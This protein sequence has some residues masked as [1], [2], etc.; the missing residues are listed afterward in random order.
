M[1]RRH[2]LTT[3]LAAAA[4]LSAAQASAADDPTAGRE[5]YEFRKYHLHV[6]SRKNRVGDFLRDVG[7]PAMNRNGIG[8]VGAFTAT[9]GP[10]DPT[11]YILAVHQSVDSVV[12]APARLLADDE[13]RT[14]GAEFVDAPLSDPAYVRFE[15]S[16]M[17]AFADMPT[18]QVPPRGGR[19][20]ELR[21]YESHSAKAALKKIEMFNEGGEI[22]I[23]KKT[24]LNPVFFGQTIIGP[25]QPNLVYMLSFKD[26]TDRDKNWQTFS[27]DPDWKKLRSDPAYKDTVSNITDIILRPTSYSQI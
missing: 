22:A 3:S 25:S 8:P 19:I 12:T 11:L 21:T 7:I 4:G 23:F 13:Y 18:L 1:N 14:R 20:F 5:Y 6:G 16:L 27:A 9:Y 10:T 15:S 26:L 2:L 17:L 24:G